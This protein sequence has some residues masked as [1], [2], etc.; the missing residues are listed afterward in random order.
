MGIKGKRVL[1]LDENFKIQNK[2]NT[3]L[4]LGLILNKDVWVP[5][6]SPEVTERGTESLNIDKKVFFNII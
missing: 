3:I 2:W 1:I 4:C 6:R 5:T